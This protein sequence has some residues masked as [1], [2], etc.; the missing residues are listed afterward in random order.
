[1]AGASRRMS[2][3]MVRSHLNRRPGRAGRADARATGARARAGLARR[4]HWVRCF[5]V[6]APGRPRESSAP[7]RRG[8]GRRPKKGRSASGGM[9]ACSAR[10]SSSRSRSTGCTWRIRRSGGRWYREF[11]PR[12][13]HAG[14]LRV[15]GQQRPGNEGPPVQPTLEQWGY[16]RRSK[17]GTA[18]RRPAHPEREEAPQ[19]TPGARYEGF[20]QREERV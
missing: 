2:L 9:A 13:R 3:C 11:R 8:R 10:A 19:A 15:D 6:D 7:E 16:L 1:M 18:W 14:G 12:A 20:S 17:A 4:P 5:V